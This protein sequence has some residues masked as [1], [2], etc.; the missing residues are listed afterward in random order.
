MLM[1]SDVMTFRS[2]GGWNAESLVNSIYET[3]MCTGVC[4][5][6]VYLFQRFSQQS[7]S[8]LKQL[9]ANSYAA[10]FIHVLVVVLQYAVESVEIGA[11][12]RFGF[13]TLV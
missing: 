12:V 2:P 7:T 8:L 1:Y 11:Y 5:G 13:V 6:L 3:F 9:S 4:I 10:Y